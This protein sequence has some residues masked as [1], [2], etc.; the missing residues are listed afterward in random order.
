VGN[1]QPVIE[2]INRPM[3][4][5]PWLRWVI[6]LSLGIPFK[7]ILDVIFSLLYRNY[8]LFQ[9]L[10]AYLRVIV[11]TL[12]AF[13]GIMLLSRWLDRVSPWERRVVRRFMMQL[14]VNVFTAL[15]F[16]IGFRWLFTSLFMQV[17]YVN[18]TD[19]MIIAVFS[20]F[21]ALNITIIQMGYFLL[22]RWRVSTAEMERFR[23]ENAEARFE[24]LRSQVNPH[25]LFNS[26]TTLSSLIYR[27][28]DKAGTFVRELSDV[29][30][31]LLD[32]RETELVTVGEEIAFIRSYLN[33][34]GLRFEDNLHI[35]LDIP[36][37]LMDRMIAPITL[38]LLVENAVKHNVI[39]KTK[40][41]SVGIYAEKDDY[42][43]VSN[44]L[45]K[46]EMLRH[47]PGMGLENIKKRYGFL[48]RREIIIV[49]DEKTFTVKIP[50]I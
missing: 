30:R 15:L 13:S 28:P 44:N 5:N 49:N 14:A 12:L 19:E 32:K 45:Q 6:I 18:F 1:L 9:P 48:T 10:T 42:I 26:L 43:V 37:H 50:L 47:S 22:A 16:V 23:K 3:I 36:V 46:K 7:F 8:V 33:L 39:S 20:V 2:D 21:I 38:Q 17:T 31:Y 4:R 35:H 34:V 11:L 27:D 24:T 25:F 41:L 29:Y 40:P